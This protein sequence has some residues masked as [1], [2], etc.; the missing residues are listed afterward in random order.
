MVAGDVCY[1]ELHQWLVESTTDEKRQAWINALQKIAALNPA[2][3]IAGHKR[4]GAV[5]GINNIFSTI[6]YI[7]RFGKLKADSRDANQLYHKMM[8]R[9]EARIDPVI[10]W[11]GC[12]ANFS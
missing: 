11:K 12:E 7:E 10:L 3:V 6:E 9:Y 5:D 1:N 4:P 8:D 2:T